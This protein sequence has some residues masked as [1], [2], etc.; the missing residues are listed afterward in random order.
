MFLLLLCVGRSQRRLSHVLAKRTASLVS[1]S[2]SSFLLLKIQFWTKPQIS[3]C[4]LT[5]TC[6]EAQTSNQQI[7]TIVYKFSV[8]SRPRV[9]SPSRSPWRTLSKPRF[10]L[11]LQRVRRDVF[12]A[13]SFCRRGS[14]SQEVGTLC[15]VFIKPPLA[16]KFSSPLASHPVGELSCCACVCVFC[17]RWITGVCVTTARARACLFFCG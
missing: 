14:S 6:L 11:Q 2:I 8:H 3:S 16:V 10:F 12:L 1:A 5:P 13:R 9:A 15:G 17:T 7:Q 4:F